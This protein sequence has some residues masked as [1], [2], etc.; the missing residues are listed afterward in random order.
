VPPL[1]LGNFVSNQRH[2][3]SSKL[4]NRCACGFAIQAEQLCDVLERET[5]LLRLFDESYPSDRC[6]RVMTITSER[7]LRFLNQPASLVVSSRLDVYSGAGG[8]SANCQFWFVISHLQKFLLIPYHSTAGSLL[9]GYLCLSQQKRPLIQQ[10]FWW[11]DIGVWV[12]GSQR[13]SLLP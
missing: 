13:S 11:R 9:F 7:F 1:Q 8:D 6:W 4:P 3:L 10:D 5:N 12:S 2:F